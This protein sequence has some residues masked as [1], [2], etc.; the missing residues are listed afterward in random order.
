MACNIIFVASFAGVD[1]ATNPRAPA[2]AKIVQ[3][4]EIHSKTGKCTILAC[5]IK[6]DVAEILLA[7]GLQYKETFLAPLTSFLY[8]RPCLSAFL[9]LPWIRSA[10]VSPISYW[11]ILNCSMIQI[12]VCCASVISS[13]DLQ[14]K[15]WCLQWETRRARERVDLFSWTKTSR[16]PDVACQGQSTK[17]LESF[18]LIR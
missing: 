15:S 5:L 13:Q 8:C 9:T 11:E 7:N 6:V 10:P 14:V 1:V 3:P 12:G 17:Q 2:L 18:S 16:C 4:E